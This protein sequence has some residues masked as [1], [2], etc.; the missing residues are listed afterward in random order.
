MLTLCMLGIFHAF[1]V[2][3]RLFSNELFQKIPPGTLS[4]SN[5]LDPYQDQHSVGPD[6]GPYCLKMISAYDTSHH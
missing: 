5:S 1:V 2:I 3:L 4:V 6:L